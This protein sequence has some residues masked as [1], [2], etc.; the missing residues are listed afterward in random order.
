[1]STNHIALHKNDAPSGT[2]CLMAVGIAFIILSF[3]AVVLAV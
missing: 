3:V 1:M 2:G